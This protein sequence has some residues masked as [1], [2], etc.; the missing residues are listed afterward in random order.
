MHKRE[1]SCFVNFPHFNGLPASLQVAA[2]SKGVANKR[3]IDNH[4]T[5]ND[6]MSPIKGARFLGNLLCSQFFEEAT[7]KIH[8][9]DDEAHEDE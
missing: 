5:Q 7:S 1:M 3:L 8:V 6:V 2:L 4:V 9:E